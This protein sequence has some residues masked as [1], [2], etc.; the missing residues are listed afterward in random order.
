MKLA[1]IAL[2]ALLPI[3]VHA[4]GAAGDTK[5]PEGT[6]LELQLKLTAT[7]DK[8]G[9]PKIAGDLLITNPTKESLT[10]QDPTN[11]L[12]LAFV[13]FD[14]LGNPLTPGGLTKVDPAFLTHSLAPQATFTHHFKN[15]NF[16]TGSIQKSYELKA[17]KT[18][19][20]IAVY[21]AAGP[22]GPG[23][24]SDEATVRIPQ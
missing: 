1:L 7:L 18:Y 9:P 4:I 2:L 13:V 8:D 20:I 5:W 23:F 21:R 19:R 17:G 24:T 22:H 16:V 3:N 15:L 11:R 12:V 6:K 14:E 10:I